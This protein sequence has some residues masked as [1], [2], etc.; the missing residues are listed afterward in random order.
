[1]KID[2]F[3]KLIIA[4][5]LFFGIGYLVQQSLNKPKPVAC[6]LEAKVCSD[7]SSV[8]RTGPNCDF[9]PCP[10]ETSCEG[11]TCSVAVVP[12][13]WKS[14]A[15]SNTG[16]SFRYPENF[17]TQYISIVDW[18]P[19]AAISNGTS[20]CVAAGSAIA[21]A[22]R[23][24]PRT[25]NGRDYCV[26]EESEGAA[27]SV[28]T[29]Y[30]YAFARENKTVILTFTLR[31]VQCANYDDPQKTACE[32]ERASFNPDNTIDQI[33]QTLKV[34]ALLPQNSGIKGNVVLGPTCPVVRNPPDPQ[35]ADKPYQ[36]KLDVMTADKSKLIAE[37][38]SGADGKFTI[39]APPGQYVIQNAAGASPL[40][41][42][43]SDGVITVFANSYIDA[44]VSCD[45]G[46]R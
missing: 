15:D 32:K 42:C 20:T 29:Q 35:C 10:S 22:G 16:V 33:A 21:P 44:T 19:A 28:Y 8:G 27:G 7:G 37:F 5:A 36:T 31:F 43:T 6:T 41:R 14:F 46:I 13:D 24:E 2:L 40:P 18:P 25:I 23:T 12:Q 39:P 4:I 9:A 30:A 34:A 17:G 3:F 38:Q 26:N 11:E 1:M 45:T